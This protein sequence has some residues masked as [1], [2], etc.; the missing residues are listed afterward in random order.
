MEQGSEGVATWRGEEPAGA[1][2]RIAANSKRLAT[3][4]RSTRRE[5]S[6]TREELLLAALHSGEKGVLVLCPL[7]DVQTA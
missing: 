1:P 4:P 2:G 6:R 5:E 3:S 7:L